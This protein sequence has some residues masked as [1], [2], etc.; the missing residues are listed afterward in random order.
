M[1][2]D[3]FESYVGALVSALTL[4][5]VYFQVSGA[6]YPLIVAG[7]GLVASIL[8]TIFRARGRECES[9]QGSEDGVLCVQCYR[10]GGGCDLQ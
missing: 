3:L 4:G 6:A 10:V 1:G 2:A 5:I 8:A 9:A 7:L